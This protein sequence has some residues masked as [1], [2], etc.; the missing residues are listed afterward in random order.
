MKP[1]R[2]FLV[3]GLFL[4]CG[5]L[6]AS[7]SWAAELSFRFTGVPA[8][9]RARLHD[10][11]TPVP[12]AKPA[13]DISDA[14]ISAAL[15]LRL[16]L[17]AYGYYD[18]RW[19]EQVV[20]K[21]GNYTL[22]FVLQPG[23][24]I[25]VRNVTLRAEGAGSGLPVLHQLFGMFPLRREGALDQPHYD[26]WKGRVLDA[27]R[28]QGYAKADFSRHEI[29]IDRKNHWADIFLT[30]DSG[31]RYRFGAVAFDGARI[32]SYHFLSRYLDFSPGDWYSPARLA[33]TQA[34]FR[35]ADRFSEIV[36]LPDLQRARNG[37]IPIRVL[38]KS[39]RPKRLKLGAGYRSDLGANLALGYDDYN[40]FQ[41]GQHLHLSTTLAQRVLDVSTSYVWPV[42]DRLGTRYITQV[43]FQHLNLIP[44]SAGVFDAGFG[45]DWYM[46]GGATLGA[47]LSYQKITYTIDGVS[48]QA[49]VT[50]PSLRYSVQNFANP[51]RPLEGDSWEA[52]IQGGARALISDANFMQVRAHGVWRH[53]LNSR[54]GVGLRAEVGTTWLA[55][56]IDNLPPTLRF[57]AGGEGTLPGYAFLSQGPGL[58]GVVL[59]GRSLLVGGADVERF[60]ARNWGIVA[61]YHAGNAFNSFTALRVLQ[62]VGL[63]VRWYSP[64]GPVRLDVAHPLVSPMAPYLRVVFSVGLSL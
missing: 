37:R 46:G 56:S 28:A 53:R 22:T 7:S 59:G 62:D 17:E 8:I 30:V 18:A 26:S 32:Y 10:T 9:L 11:M 49:R 16:A 29:L 60:I 34:N 19:Q 2:P 1:R 61:F 23:P 50:M 55:G 40:A 57:F 27:L 58:D 24:Q 39:L 43:S 6:V 51:V 41:R 63:G 3:C 14:R 45:R 12:L 52:V 5:L 21:E 35:N 64:F 25:R 20:G 44:Y 38:L 54:W 48:G 15:R 31:S 36:V 33:R 42:G 4:A 13:A 47:F